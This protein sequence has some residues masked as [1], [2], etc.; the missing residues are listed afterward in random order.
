MTI[1]EFKRISDEI[2][3]LNERVLELSHKLE[4]E[5]N[6]ILDV[7]FPIDVD[8]MPNLICPPYNIQMSDDGKEILFQDDTQWYSIPS[9]W[10]QMSNEDVFENYKQL[11]ETPGGKTDFLSFSEPFSLN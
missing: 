3:K 5:L 6:R 11:L 4:T 9:I 7:I 1:V 2:I 8:Y 10:L